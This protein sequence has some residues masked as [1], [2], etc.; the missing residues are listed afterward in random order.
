MSDALYK[1]LNDKKYL[2][3][4]KE[5]AASGSDRFKMEKLI[6]EIESYFEEIVRR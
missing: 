4:L 5:K 2:L 6:N 1:L 3:D